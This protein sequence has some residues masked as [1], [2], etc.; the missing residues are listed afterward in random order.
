LKLQPDVDGRYGFNIQ[1]GFN[2]HRSL[3]GFTSIFLFKVGEKT[4]ISTVIPNTPASRVALHEGDIILAVNHINIRHHSHAE[5][6][7]NKLE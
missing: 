5:V 7:K 6:K 1:V 3:I 2:G 4:V